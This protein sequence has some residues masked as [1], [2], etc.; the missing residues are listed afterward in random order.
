MK[1]LNNKMHLNLIS[2]HTSYRLHSQVTN[3]Y[4]QLNKTKTLRELEYT[5]V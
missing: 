3:K 4:H 1:I 5:L 2:T